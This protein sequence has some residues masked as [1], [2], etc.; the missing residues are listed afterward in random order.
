MIFCRGFLRSVPDHVWLCYNPPQKPRVPYPLSS[1]NVPNGHF[2]FYKENN[3]GLTKTWENPL[4]NPFGNSSKATT[5]SFCKFTSLYSEI[6][7]LYRVSQLFQKDTFSNSKACFLETRKC[8]IYVHYSKQMSS[9]NLAV[10][11]SVNQLEIESFATPKKSMKLE[12]QVRF[13]RC[14]LRLN[15]PD[16][17]GFGKTNGSREMMQTCGKLR[18]LTTNS[19]QFAQ[20]TQQGQML[21]GCYW[22]RISEALSKN[23]NTFELM[24]LWGYVC[25]IQCTT[26]YS[27]ILFILEV[28]VANHRV[29][30]QAWWRYRVFLGGLNQL[31]KPWIIVAFINWPRPR[32]QWS[33]VAFGWR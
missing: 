25:L 30:L 1:T 2:F 16:R 12:R 28:S 10:G 5:F 6:F 29:I 31:T 9:W 19:P 7:E 27:S 4:Q 3:E 8:E 23:R 13:S 24:Y 15:V 26:H 14:L 18:L 33:D 22:E 11:F 32:L 21:L 20:R 17:N